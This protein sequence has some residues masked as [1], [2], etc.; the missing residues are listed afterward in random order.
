[1]TFDADLFRFLSDLAENNSRDW[2]QEN[3]DRY[4]DSVQ[5]PSLQFVSDMGPL[6]ETISPRFRAIPKKVGGSL[7]RIHRDVRFSKDKSPY[8][9]HVGIRFPH[10]R[11]KDVHT[12]GFYLHLQPGACFAGLGLWHPASKDLR[13]IRDA[14]VE[15]PDRW[16]AARDDANLREH[17]EFGGGESLKRAP[18]GVDA[19]HPLIEDLKRKDFLASTQ[20]DDDAVLDE[21][22]PLRVAEIFRAGLPL[23]AFLCGALGLES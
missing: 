20:L 7:F 12:P 4:V 15:D 14:I 21:D 17:L 16:V 9:T 8:K 10:E 13:A 5:E 3:R 22:L 23:V 6:L 2:F 19:D 1:M 18:R 11:S